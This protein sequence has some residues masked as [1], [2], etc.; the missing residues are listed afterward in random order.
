MCLPT[1]AREHIVSSLGSGSASTGAHEASPQIVHAIHSAF[2]S[3]LGTGLEIGAA[4]MV[5]G[6][7]LAWILIERTPAPQPAPAA[8]RE[9]ARHEQAAEAT[10]VS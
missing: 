8:E 10:L 6:A 7:V 3:A 2:I 5:V 4:V 9:R 1:S